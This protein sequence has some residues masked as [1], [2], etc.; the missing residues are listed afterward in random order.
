MIYYDT[1]KAIYKKNFPFSDL[2]NTD[3]FCIYLQKN[4]YGR[5]FVIV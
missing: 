2:E 3:I 1:V 4:K 5:K